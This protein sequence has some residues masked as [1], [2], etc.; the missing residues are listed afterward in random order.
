MSYDSMQVN[1][2]TI[3]GLGLMGLE[4]WWFLLAK[5]KSRQVTAQ[6]GIQA[7]T[8]T[9]NDGYEPSNIVVQAGQLVRLNFDRRDPSNC[10]EGVRIPDFRIAQKLILN[11][12]T[13]I[14]FMPDHPGRYEFSCGMN[15]FRGVIEVQAGDLGDDVDKRLAELV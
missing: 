13:P 14:E 4:L 8:V 6:G 2:E 15:M 12:I 1:E 11:Q 7:V 5:P 3:G 9:V 10:L